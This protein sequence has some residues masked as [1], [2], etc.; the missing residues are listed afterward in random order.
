MEAQVQQLANQ[1]AAL[2]QEHQAV[3]AQLQAAQQQIAAMQ[4][5]VVA[6][7]AQVQPRIKPPKPPVFTGRN[8]EPS[9]TNWTHQMEAYLRAN[10]V[11][12]NNPVAVTYAA[13]FLAD[14]ALTWHRM[15][16][17][18]VGRGVTQDY[19]N[20]EQFR[21]ALITR[22]TPISPEETARRKLATL[23]QRQSVRAYAE[24]FNLCMIEL[25]GM[26][27]RDRI[28]RFLR[29]LKPEV[30]I[31]V[32]LKGPTTLAEAIEWAI[33][34][35]SLVWQLKKGAYQGPTYRQVVAPTSSGPA[36]MELGAMENKTQGRS[37][38]I[39][40]YCKGEGHIKRECPKLRKRPGFSTAASRSN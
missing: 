4:P 18:D 19:A 35:D 38:M 26:D 1:L 30:A 32:E 12:L 23:K 39:C 22:F 15:H 36:P 11:D 21:T 2:T 28:F 8:R 37:K 17:R 29:G 31:H 9:P 13:G 34:A 7:G 33:K 25:P 24:E 27:E 16:T 6:A 20:W 10:G 14:S 3:V 5:N 40:F